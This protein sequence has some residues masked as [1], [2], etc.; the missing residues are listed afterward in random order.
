MRGASFIIFITI[1]LYNIILFRALARV[2]YCFSFMETS[3]ARL[4][5]F[6]YP[7]QNVE[8]QPRAAAVLIYIAAVYTI[9][10]KNSETVV[11]THII[12]CPTSKV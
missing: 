6:K 9:I 11:K 1:D 8:R 5:K 4:S 7:G 12:I 2:Y 10:Y 3:L